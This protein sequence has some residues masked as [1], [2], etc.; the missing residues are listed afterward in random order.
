LGYAEFDN[1]NPIFHTIISDN[2]PRGGNPATFTYNNIIAI[3][4]VIDTA[5]A[6][7]NESAGTGISYVDINDNIWKYL[8]QSID[9]IPVAGQYHTI[10][11]GGQNLTALAVTTEINNISYGGRRF[12]SSS[13][14]KEEGP[15]I[16]R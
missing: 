1:S 11:W 12:K 13:H 5:V 10:E 6:T 4:G 3:S 14:Y 9:S 7:G 15:L 16:S 8:P 2:L